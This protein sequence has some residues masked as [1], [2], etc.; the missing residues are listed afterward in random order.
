MRFTKRVVSILCILSLVMGVL[1]AWVGGR[2]VEVK[3]EENFPATITVAGWSDDSYDKANDY[4]QV[5][6]STGSAISIDIGGSSFWSNGYV[7]AEPAD[8]YELKSA[9]IF[10]NGEIIDITDRLSTLSAFQNSFGETSYLPDV[11]V[12]NLESHSEDA[13]S[14]KGVVIDR[15]FYTEISYYAGRAPMFLEFA[16]TED[17]AETYTFTVYFQYDNFQSNTNIAVGDTI[18]IIDFWKNHEPAHFQDFNHDLMDDGINTFTI[19]D[20]EIWIDASSDEMERLEGYDCAY[21]AKMGGD[22]TV[23]L[24]NKING[25]SYEL[26]VYAGYGEAPFRVADIDVGDLEIIPF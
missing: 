7:L 20:Y 18:D 26:F 9:S 3:A 2:T 22:F 23:S 17:E 1:G 15:A 8:G 4:A 24:T 14:I 12:S 19:D 11:V 25:L 5:K 13:D 16:N 10:P 6:V 21:F